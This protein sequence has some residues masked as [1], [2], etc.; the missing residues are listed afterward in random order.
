[1]VIDILHRWNVKGGGEVKGAEVEVEE[2]WGRKCGFIMIH[3]HHVTLHST[4]W[5]TLTFLMLM[6]DNPS[7]IWLPLT[8]TRTHQTF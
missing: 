1:M 3:D 4:H 8:V 7:D 5:D 6:A 2:R